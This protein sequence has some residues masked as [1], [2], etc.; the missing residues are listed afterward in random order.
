MEAV[1][2]AAAA[3]ER[4]ETEASRARLARDAAV[5]SAV[6][7]GI[8]RGHVAEAAGIS[9]SLVTRIMNAPRS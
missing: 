8:Q 7:A 2:Q 1:Q 6:K 9:G 5:R 4:A 3:L